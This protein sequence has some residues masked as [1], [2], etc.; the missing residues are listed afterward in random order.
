M[1]AV[2][3]GRTGPGTLA[4]QGR[5]G[6]Q[7]AG[8]SLSLS[9]SWPASSALPASVER[10]LL[11]AGPRARARSLVEG[12]TAG[13]GE[14]CRMER[15]L[16]EGS[17]RRWRGAI[18]GEEERSQEVSDRKWR[19]VILGRG[20]RSQVEGSDRRWRGAMLS[21]SLWRGAIAGGGERF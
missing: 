5:L 20:G 11:Q 8:G 2:R 16:V 18:A 12:R 19:G 17:D 14:Q 21:D 10:E 3:A 9:L 13:E 4:F 15:S 1:R 6:F 7:S